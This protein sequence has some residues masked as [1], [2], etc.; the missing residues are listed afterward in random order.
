MIPRDQ[1]GERPGRARTPRAAGDPTTRNCPECLSE[2]PVAACRC[3]F[4]AAEIGAAA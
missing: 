3:A 1:A 4:C 2:I